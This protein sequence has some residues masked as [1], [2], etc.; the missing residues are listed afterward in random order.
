MLTM[1]M[2][3]T[4]VAAPLDV[5]EEL[6]PLR[7]LRSARSP[8]EPEDAAYGKALD[9]PVAGIEPVAGTTAK[10]WGVLIVPEPIEAVWMAVNDEARMGG[11]LPV[12]LS[13]VIGGDARRAPR[14]VFEYMPLPIISDRWWVVDVSHNAEL[15][16]AS[17]GRMWEV[18]WT[19]ATRRASLEGSGVEE[20]ARS[21]YPVDWTYGGWLLTDLGEQGTII[22]YY[23]WSDPGGAIPA[24]ASRFAGGA[25]RQTLT[26]IAD[27]AKESVHRDR[28]GFV[29]PDGTPL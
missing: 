11:K 26:A 8:A 14:R 29:R 24:G 2:A 27:L 9:R 4:A 21:G 23:S 13:R 16:T 5:V 12:S 19:D 25:I 1:W 17:G 20:A 22:E 6:R 3:M 15:Y 18:S 10:G 28:T 7:S